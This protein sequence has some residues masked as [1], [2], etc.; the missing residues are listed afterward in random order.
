MLRLPAAILATLLLLPLP[1]CSV[2]GSAIGPAAERDGPPA[3]AATLIVEVRGDPRWD[4]L[5]RG[6]LCMDRAEWLGEGPYAHGAE[7]AFLEGVAVL[8]FEAVPPGRWPLKVHLDLDRD[9]RLARGR[10]GM[11]A[12]PIAFGNDAAPRF[13]P[14]P[15]E[16]ASIEIAAGENLA[17]VRLIGEAPGS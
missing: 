16:A 14:P 6:A 13:G 17:T 8:R 2:P 9:G 15:M 3:A 5:V 12:E 10:F 7:A 4:G 11:P 1:A